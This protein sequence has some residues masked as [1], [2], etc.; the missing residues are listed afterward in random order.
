V[1]VEEASANVYLG[2]QDFHIPGVRF[3]RSVHSGIGGLNYG[4]GSSSQVSRRL[5]IINR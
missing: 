1:K 2:K 4:I 3:R 5:E